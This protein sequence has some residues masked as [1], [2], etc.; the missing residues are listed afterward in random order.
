MLPVG[1]PKCAPGALRIRR[2]VTTLKLQAGAA[3]VILSMA[4]LSQRHPLKVLNADRDQ[5]VR[6]LRCLALTPA[7]VA[8]ENMVSRLNQS[9]LKMAQETGCVEGLSPS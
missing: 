4:L 1:H 5:V 2:Q 8:S 3:C 7:R 9:L 6:A